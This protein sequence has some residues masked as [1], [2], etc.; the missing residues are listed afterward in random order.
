MTDRLTII[1]FILLFP[2]TSD[3]QDMVNRIQCDYVELSGLVCE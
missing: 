2:V 1:L 3:E